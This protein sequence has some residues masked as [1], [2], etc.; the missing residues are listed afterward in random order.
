[1]ALEN[2][3]AMLKKT[4]ILA[5]SMLADTLK[6][7]N[8]TLSQPES[9]TKQVRLQKLVDTI[10]INIDSL[11]LWD[12]TNHRTVEALENGRIRPKTLKPHA[13]FSAEKYDEFYSNQS[14]KI[15]KLANRSEEP[16][17]Q[18]TS[19]D[20][21]RDLSRNINHG[22]RVSYGVYLVE[23]LFGLLAKKN[24]D[25]PIRWLD[26]GCG[27]GSIINT[28]NP[29]RYGCQAWEITGCDMQEGKIEL[30]NHYKL[31]DRQFFPKE[32][33]ALLSEMSTQNTPYDII[34]MFE[35]LEHLNDPL[36]FLEKL[37]KFRSELILIASPLAQVIG[38]PFTKQPDPVHLWSFSR[39]GLEKMLDI[40]G[41]EVVYSAEIRVGSYVG[42][43]DWLTVVCGDK[44]LFKEK[45]TDWQNFS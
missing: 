39:E 3:V 26:I 25:Q 19:N 14:S 33:F 29:Q 20:I 13:R 21:N 41:L 43:L 27:I 18:P 45:R 44:A 38:K 22:F 5:F 9:D 30:A 34:S 28:V 7:A 15:S 40:A 10:Q 32:A 36:D 37:A 11:V 35:F 42:G 31:P 16:S 4:H 6:E 1:S 8:K 23:V 24:G 17:Q 12:Q 2:N